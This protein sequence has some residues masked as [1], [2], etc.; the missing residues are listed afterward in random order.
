MSLKTTPKGLLAALAATSIVMLQMPAV[1]GHLASAATVQSHRTAAAAH[2]VKPHAVKP[3]DINVGAF[4]ISNNIGPVGTVVTVTPTASI[5]TSTPVTVTFTDSASAV[6]TATATVTSAVGVQIQI[7]L[8]AA[9]GPGTIAV[10][11]GAAAP[12]STSF[13]VLNKTATASPT[14]GTRGTSVAVTLA[15]YAPSQAIVPTLVYSNAATNGISVTALTAITPP[16]D[17]NGNAV[18]TVTIPSSAAYGTSVVISLTASYPVTPTSG[19]FPSVA[20]NAAPAI[21][22]SPSAVGAAGISQTITVSTTGTGTFIITSTAAPANPSI[23]LVIG[24]QNQ[25]PTAITPITGTFSTSGVFTTTLQ[26][27]PTVAGTYVITATDVNGNNVAAGTFQ[28]A[29][30]SA[31]VATSYLAEGYTGGAGTLAFHTLLYILNPNSV[32]VN[33]TNTYVLQTNTSS[34]VTTTA[35]SPP[36]VVVVTHTIGAFG[37]AVIDAAADIATQPVVSGPDVGKTVSGSNQLVATIVKT[38]GFT[39]NPNVR[40]VAVERLIERISGNAVN[41]TFADGD[42]E[43]ATSSANTS[44]YFAEGY[45]G[46]TFQMYLILFNPS[47]TVTATVNVIPAPESSTATTGTAPTA[48]GPYVLAP[49]QRLTLNMRALN[50]GNPPAI[51]MIVNS[52]NAIVAERTQYFGAGSG[53][54]KAGQNLANGS[55]TAAKTLVFAYGSLTGGPDVANPVTGTIVP[56]S[57]LQQTIDDRPFLTIMNPNIANQTIAGTQSGSA[58]SPGPA[59]HVTIQLRGEDGR[60]LGFFISDVDAGTR[61]TLTTADLTS[62]SGGIGFPGVPRAQPTRAGVFSAFVSSSE[63]IVAE[64]SNYYGQGPNTP[65]GDANAGA[66]GITLVGSPTGQ[67]DVIFPNLAPSEPIAGQGIQSTVFLYNPGVNTIKVSGAFY[68]ITGTILQTYT[69]NP[70]QIQVIGRSITDSGGTGTAQGPA[71]PAGT[72]GAEF[73]LVPQRGSTNGTANGVPG[74]LGGPSGE[75]GQPA[76]GFVAAA[77]SH[78]A[79]AAQWWGTQGYYPLPTTCSTANGCS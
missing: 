78:S 59:A 64:L 32:S 13:V 60:L 42:V 69:I 68:T 77:I 40:G 9:S 30:P 38:A 75:P 37:V 55:S 43:L 47:P 23:S 70:D 53:S 73:A 18:T 17:I 33:I 54:G 22:V 58:T 8:T 45:T 14:T 31:P 28:V 5:T 11:V 10:T 71:M 25:T 1:T 20:L 76:D 24:L 79:D 67:T 35:P 4:I 26:F 44:F 7:P 49:Y 36:D 48:L 46:I 72:L 21:A 15:G 52:D 19:S 39:D 56:T 27:T 74:T 65:T 62:G 57:D 50:L 16:V 51:G 61:F 66:P 63:R 12:A 6:V 34:A 2:V 41:P 29:V 3:H